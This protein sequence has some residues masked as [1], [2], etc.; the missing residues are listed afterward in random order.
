M[1]ECIYPYAM[2]D[3]G[4]LAVMA[5]DQLPVDVVTHHNYPH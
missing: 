3:S 5:L 4:G 2:V 1:S